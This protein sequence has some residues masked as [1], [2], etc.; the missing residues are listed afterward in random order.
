MDKMEKLN[1]IKGCLYGVADGDAMGLPVEFQ[2]KESI[3]KEYGVI[4]KFIGG[5]TWGKDKGS[6]SDDTE[7]MLAVATGIIHNPENPIGEI[8]KCF[9]DWYNEEPFDVGICCSNV[10]GRVRNEMALHGYDENDWHKCA[11]AYSEHGNSGGNGALM[12]TAYV[13]CYYKDVVD[14]I[15]WAREIC[16]MTHYDSVAALDCAIVSRII[17]DLIDGGDEEIIKKHTLLNLYYGDRFKYFNVGEYDFD[18]KPNGYGVHSLMCALHSVLTT[19]SFKDAII[20]AVNMGG[21]TDTIGA[22][23]GSIAGALYGYDGIPKE[24]A[25]GVEW[26]ARGR[27]DTILPY[28]YQQRCGGELFESADVSGRSEEI[29][30]TGSKG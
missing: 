16:K 30:S 18:V 11:K 14:V 27:I 4:D 13:G 9:I 1:R 3:Q 22:I 12:R 15:Y 21:D 28:A 8:G 7:M 2:N 23:T 5:G 10:I 17:H 29:V 26:R 25:E 24:W 20:K 6:V 19:N